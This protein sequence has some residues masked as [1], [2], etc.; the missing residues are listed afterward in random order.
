ME[1]GS[2]DPA[3]E[4]HGGR[5]FRP[6][7]TRST[8]SPGVPPANSLRILTWYF[9]ETSP[10]RIGDDVPNQLDDVFV[11][12]NS[13][14]EEAVLPQTLTAA[15]LVREARALLRQSNKAMEICVL[16]TGG[17]ERVNVI[18][19]E[20][21][22]RNCKPLRG[23]TL[24]K[25][26]HYRAD[27]AGVCEGSAPTIRADREEILTQTE[28][29]VPVEAARS[30]HARKPNARFLPGLKTRPPLCRRG[31]GSKDPASIAPT[32]CRV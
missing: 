25:L 4:R 29:H 10:N 3:E 17:N 9:R 26:Q 28:I 21:V 30:A 11:L 2:L 15:L 12:S 20:A 32:G 24:Q 14:V 6:G 18:R 8:E 13:A 16:R 22:R 5:V 27:Y 1:A 23:G 7:E 31:A 19:H